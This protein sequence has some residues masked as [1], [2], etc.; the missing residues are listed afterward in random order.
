M[1]NDRMTLYVYVLLFRCIISWQRTI[2]CNWFSS[3]S[4]IHIF[5]SSSQAQWVNSGSISWRWKAIWGSTRQLRNLFF[6]FFSK[7]IPNMM[8]ISLPVE[9]VLL[10]L[11]LEVLLELVLLVLPLE[12]LLELVP[13]VVLLEV[14]V[15]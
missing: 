10:V 15:L 5:K 7:N 2:Y 11:P 4:F 14:L 12:V 8:K 3:S 13:L 1:M 6:F 9:E